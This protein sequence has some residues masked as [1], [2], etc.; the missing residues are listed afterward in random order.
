MAH[1]IRQKLAIT[2]HV[3]YTSMEAIANTV[4]TWTIN[5]STKTG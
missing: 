1:A 5:N 4:R 3:L 2:A